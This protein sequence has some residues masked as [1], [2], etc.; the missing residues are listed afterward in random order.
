MRNKLLDELQEEY[1]GYQRYSTS[2]DY[3][4]AHVRL[5]R[6][7]GMRDQLG[8]KYDNSVSLR[9]FCSREASGHLKRISGILKKIHRSKNHHLKKSSE[10][11]LIQ[12]ATAGLI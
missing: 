7:L 3:H 1:R 6:S 2:C 9:N 8:D 4:D 11:K 12:R 5:I 10:F